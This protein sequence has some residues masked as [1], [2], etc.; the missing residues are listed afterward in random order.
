MTGGLAAGPGARR[1][2]AAASRGGDRGGRVARLPVDAAPLRFPTWVTY[3]KGD[4]FCLCDALARA[5]RA[6]DRAGER[7]EAARLAA[8]FEVLESGLT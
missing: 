7:D 5:E 1:I 3:A 6:L 4:V 8:A 2:V